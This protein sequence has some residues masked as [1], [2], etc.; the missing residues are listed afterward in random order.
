MRGAGKARILPLRGEGLR[1]DTREAAQA[2][3][4]PRA[5]PSGSLRGSVY[6]HIKASVVGTVQQINRNNFPVSIAGEVT[7]FY[8]AGPKEQR[9]GSGIGPQGNAGM[10]RQ[11]AL[12]LKQ[13]HTKHV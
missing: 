2:L 10:G 5:G 3:Q 1:Q 9:R 4:I 11:Q 7:G 13:I 12:E 6:I 8:L